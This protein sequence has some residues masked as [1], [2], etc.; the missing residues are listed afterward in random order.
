[1]EEDLEKKLSIIESRLEVLIQILCNDAMSRI[2]QDQIDLKKERDEKNKEKEKADKLQER[3]NLM[4]ERFIEPSSRE[5]Y[6]TAFE[7]L[8]K[9]V[10]KK[11]ERIENLKKDNET[12]REKVSS[13]RLMYNKQVK[14]SITIE[15]ELK[16]LKEKFDALEKENTSLKK[17]TV[18]SS[19]PQI[20]SARIHNLEEELREVRKENISLKEEKTNSEKVI[21]LM[22]QIE[23]LKKENNILKD[24]LN[25]PK[26]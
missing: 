24:I 23:E 6:K 4:M 21:L 14:N 25:D 2:N 16:N 12:L 20:L 7:N 18:S 1:M 19:T 13:M 22:K 26:K 9:N 5:D 15:K 10:V 8:Q 17:R 3:L 11:E